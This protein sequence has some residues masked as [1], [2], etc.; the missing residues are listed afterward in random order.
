MHRCRARS[1]GV[2]GT[3]DLACHHLALKIEHRG[4]EGEVDERLLAVAQRIE[5]ALLTVR[6]LLEDD[7]DLGDNLLEPPADEAEPR[8]RIDHVVMKVRPAR[9]QRL[10]D[11][12]DGRLAVEGVVTL[13]LAS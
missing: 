11:G 5:A 6:S 8:L 9:L 2:V 3:L 4:G 1:V 10:A 13:S 7:G 12:G